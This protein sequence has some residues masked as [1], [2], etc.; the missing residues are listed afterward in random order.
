MGL[1]SDMRQSSMRRNKAEIDKIDEKHKDAQSIKDVGLLDLG[2]A[3]YHHERFKKLENMGI[4][5]EMHNDGTLQ[6]LRQ[7][8][9][10]GGTP[11][12]FGAGFWAMCASW[13]GAFESF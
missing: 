10:N 12:G 9:K 6:Q 3:M 8:A 1:F 7:H 2:K 4:V 11:T 13:N 5:E